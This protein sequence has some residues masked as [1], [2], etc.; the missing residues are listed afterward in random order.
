MTSKRK[1]AVLK[2]AEEIG[3]V[4]KACRYFGITRQ[5]FY[6]WK[7]AYQHLGENGLINSRP[8][9]ANPKLRIPKAVDE[10]I[11]YLRTTY[12]LGQLRISWFLERYHGV[13][14]SPTGAH[15][16]LKRNGLNKLP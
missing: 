11:I 2:Y 1:P 8:C 3:N 6:K 14:V 12:H 9:P 16:V 10:K 13:K 4:S 7:R 15:Y 5:S